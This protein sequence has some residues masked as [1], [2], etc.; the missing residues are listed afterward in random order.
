LAQAFKGLT[1]NI[2]LSN[3]NNDLLPTEEPNRR[4]RSE[5]PPEIAAY[6]EAPLPRHQLISR[7]W[8]R[9]G[10]KR[11]TDAL[12]IDAEHVVG[13]LETELAPITGDKA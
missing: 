11:Q 1:S 7:L 10:V 2:L 3:G 13:F 5:L 12:N 4:T 9:R 8:V 6:F